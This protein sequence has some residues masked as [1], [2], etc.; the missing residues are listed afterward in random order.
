VGSTEV[1]AEVEVWDKETRRKREKQ[2]K[3]EENRR[4]I[5]AKAESWV[6][7]RNRTWKWLYQAKSVR[8]F[9]SPRY[10]E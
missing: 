2:K 5:R 3:I 7:P 6:K 1:E 10:A 9:A 8:R 4:A